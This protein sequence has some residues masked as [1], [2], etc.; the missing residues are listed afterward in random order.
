MDYDVRSSILNKKKEKQSRR[1]LPRKTAALAK[2]PAPENQLAS[3]H[4]AMLQSIMELCGENCRMWLE[5]LAPELDNLTQTHSVKSP[6]QFNEA[7]RMLMTEL[8]KEVRYILLSLWS[9]R[10]SKLLCHIDQ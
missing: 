4:S 3:E 9:S 1:Q 2:V 8:T 5:K 6:E 7:L 10:S